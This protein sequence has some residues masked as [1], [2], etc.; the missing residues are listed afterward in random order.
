MPKEKPQFQL[1]ALNLGHPPDRK[2]RGI[3]IQ[4]PTKAINRC[5]VFYN[6]IALKTPFADK[7]ITWAYIHIG[8]SADFRI[9]EELVDK[10]NAIITIK[11]GRKT[12]QKIKLKELPYAL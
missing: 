11:D 12:I 7:M 3:H 8:G 1:T 9:P 10:E 2:I 4:N 5:Q 6:G